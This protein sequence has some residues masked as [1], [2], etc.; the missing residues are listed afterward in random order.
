[1]V[2]AAWA[3]TNADKRAYEPV[4]AADRVSCRP[5]F[6]VLIYPGGLLERGSKIGGGCLDPLVETRP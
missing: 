4:D 6:A 2:R 5:D 1:V 3:G